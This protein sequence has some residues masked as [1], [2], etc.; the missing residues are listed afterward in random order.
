[1]A[2]RE[3][4]EALATTALAARCG[5]LGEISP[6]SPIATKARDLV[7]EWALLQT[8]PSP[9]HKLQRENDAKRLDRRN[10]MIEFLE[11]NE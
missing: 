6:D 2:S 1:M 8:P 4:L 11:A 3:F 7:H 10:R 5:R 9:S